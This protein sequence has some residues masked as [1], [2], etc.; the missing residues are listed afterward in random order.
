MIEVP[1][2]WAA[3]RALVEPT[4]P[5]EACATCTAIGGY[6]SRFEKHGEVSD[7]IPS[8]VQ[9]LEGFMES[10]RGWRGSVE[11]CKICHRLYWYEVE[12]EFL[13]GGSE[14]TTSYRRM[15]PEELF[16]DDWFI[17]YRLG[18]DKVD[19]TYA[20]TFFREHSFATLKGEGW[21]ALHDEGTITPL[22]PPD[23]LADII[24]VD[25]LAGLSDPRVA[26]SY[27]YFI[28]RFRGIEPHRGYSNFNHI[29]WKWT[30]TVDEKRQIEDLR[31]A[32]RVEA[33]RVERLAD[34]VTIT[35]WVVEQRRLIC[36]A[37]NIFPNGD[38]V[39]EDAVIGEDLPLM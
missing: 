8:A 2:T 31:A 39:N 5:L 18:P 14:D 9:G 23:G 34:R 20:Q 25:P 7:D 35:H 13:V 29:P 27:W 37:I 6:R 10:Q 11:W 15:E 21:I 1:K 17:R 22:V 3:F 38:I 32:S 4:L 24:A 30:P 19:R 33:E 16:R 26:K 28:N 12:Y 36:R